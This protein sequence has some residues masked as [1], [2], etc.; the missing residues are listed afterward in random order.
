MI[1]ILLGQN[2]CS[3]NKLNE[4]GRVIRNNERL[5]C[6]GYAEQEGIDFEETFPPVARLEAIRT[7]L[8]L[9]IFCNFKVC[10][11]DV[12]FAFLNGDLEEEVYIEKPEGFILGN[13]KNIF[14]Q[15]KKAL[16]GLKKAPCAW[17]S[18]LDKYIQQQGFQRVQ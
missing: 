16:Y 5:V 12:K 2:G 10:R 1:K 6:K 8:A 14:C 17:Y 4:N 18:H 7:F 13:H 9:S 15:I 3:K 11:M